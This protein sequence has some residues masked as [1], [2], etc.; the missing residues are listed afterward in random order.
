MLCLAFCLS[1]SP[2]LTQ[3]ATRMEETWEQV[4]E[5]PVLHS[6]LAQMVMISRDFDFVG[7]SVYSD[8]NSRADIELERAKEVSE[9]RASARGVGSASGGDRAGSGAAGADH[10]QEEWER[11][12]PEVG[13]LMFVGPGYMVERGGLV[14]VRVSHGLGGFSAELVS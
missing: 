8:T 2:S 5:L 6:G 11:P 4:M 7:G 13:Q 12:P 1:V 9:N 14:R 3:H 10:D